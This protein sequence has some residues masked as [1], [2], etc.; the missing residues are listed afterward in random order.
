MFQIYVGACDSRDLAGL[1]DRA[2]GGE[3][4]GVGDGGGVKLRLRWLE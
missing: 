1:G 4:G 3:G 2:G